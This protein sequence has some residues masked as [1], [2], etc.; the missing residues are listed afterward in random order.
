MTDI[1]SLLNEALAQGRWLALPIALAGGVITSLNPCCIPFYPAA[2]AACCA[3]REEKRGFSVTAA[4][5]AGTASATSILGV[6]AALAGKTLTSWT[7]WAA[8]L[9]ALIPLIAGAH[10]LGL[11]RI[12]MPTLKK[13][14]SLR[15]LGGAFIGGLLLSCLIAPCGTPILAAI[16]AWAAMKGSAVYGGLLLFVYGVGIGAPLLLLG[17]FVNRLAER[18]D[19][20]GYRI[21][22]DRFTGTAL[23]GVGF[24][25]IWI[26]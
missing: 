2:A 6:M 23:L 22:I 20:R 21:W 13:N 12:P 18:L 25:L 7:G 24:Y 16:L 5:V 8:Y 26:A 15:G 11:L 1:S 10:F 17:A 9:I 14:L 19:R 3:T 4:F